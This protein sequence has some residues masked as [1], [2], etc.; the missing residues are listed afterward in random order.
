MGSAQLWR[1]AQHA[2]HQLAGRACS[3]A[4]VESSSAGTCAHRRRAPSWGLC[5]GVLC[6]RPTL[7]RL[8]LVAEWFVARCPHMLHALRADGAQFLLELRVLLLK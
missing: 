2:M 3:L 5:Q 6:A 4:C 1:M 8:C 7:S